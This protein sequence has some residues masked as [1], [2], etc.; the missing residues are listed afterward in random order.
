M[1]C[2]APLVAAMPLSVIALFRLPERITFTLFA[3][4]GTNRAC[5]MPKYPLLQSASYSIRPR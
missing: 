5:L 4:A 3:V 2:L 1:A